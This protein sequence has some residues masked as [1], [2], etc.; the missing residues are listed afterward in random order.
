[1][2]VGGN[3]EHVGLYAIHE[4]THATTEQLFIPCYQACVNEV[5]QMDI[6]IEAQI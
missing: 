6:F 5:L 1:M 4:A 3:F 2:R